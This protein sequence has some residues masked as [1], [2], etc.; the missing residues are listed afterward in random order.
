MGKR[1]FSGRYT[2]ENQDD[3]VIFIFGMRVNKWFAVHKWLPVFSAMPP[4]MKEL[5]E[6]RDKLG[7]LSMETYFGLRTTVMIQ[8]WRSLEDLLSY[9]RNDKHLIAWRDFN[10]K[11]GNNPAVGIFHESYQVKKE[12]YESVYGNMP[13]HGLSKALPQI[14]ITNTSNGARKRLK[15]TP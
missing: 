6:N 11:V 9:A 12:H 3:L 15:T 1:I 10:R 7:F 8:Y 2:T 13:L 14:P 5:R 4:M